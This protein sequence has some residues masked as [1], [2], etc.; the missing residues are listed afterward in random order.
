VLS[1]FAPSVQY[2]MLLKMREAQNAVNRER[3]VE[4]TGQPAD[5]STFQMQTFLKASNFRRAPHP[6]VCA[7]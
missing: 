2:E 1:T 3:F 7:A 4:R 6:G 5:F